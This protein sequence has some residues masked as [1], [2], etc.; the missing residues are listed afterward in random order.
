MTPSGEADGSAVGD[1][2]YLL[3]HTD[4]ELRRLDLQGELYR[5]ITRRAFLRAGLEP[6]MR[7]LDIGC[8]TGDVSLTAAELVGETGYVL[9]IDRGAEAV[10]AARARAKARGASHVEFETV[11]IDELQVPE[12]FDALVG[13]F[14][15]MHQPEPAETLRSGARAVRTGGTVVMVESYM[16]LL[17]TGGHSEPHSPLYDDIVRF[18]CSVVSGAGADLHAGG[19][20]RR[21]FV[22]AG[23]SDPVCRLETRVE[24]G[25]D[26]PYYEYVAQSVRSMLPEARRLGVEGFGEDDVPELARRLREEI[27]ELGGSLLV[28]PVVS[29]WAHV[30]R[31]ERQVVAS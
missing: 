14:V 8:G 2:H 13:R 18:K 24:G 6:G 28:W 22:E 15:L 19:R 16:E 1:R 31:P 26:S 23:L 4:S 11:E 25:P 21:T 10:A 17:R 20:L 3:G 7:V 5:D 12:A 30:H 9:G 29:A 27:L